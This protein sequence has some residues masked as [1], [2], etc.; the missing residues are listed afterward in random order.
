MLTSA[1]VLDWVAQLSGKLWMSPRD[2]GL[3]VRGLDVVLHFQEMYC[4]GEVDHEVS[5]ARI[6]K[7]LQPVH[8]RFLD[9]VCK[10]RGY[11]V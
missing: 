2:L 9:D 11:S 8:G 5:E 4:G 3:L 1:Q 7:L 6:R 10:E